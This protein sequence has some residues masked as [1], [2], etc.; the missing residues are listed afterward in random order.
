MGVLADLNYCTRIVPNGTI[1]RLE[2]DKLIVNIV[3]ECS[4]IICLGIR[5]GGL[6]NL[7]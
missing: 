5:D 4:L 1:G 3:H 6:T 2:E 7:H